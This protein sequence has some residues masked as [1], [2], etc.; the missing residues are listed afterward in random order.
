MKQRLGIAQAMLDSPPVIFMD[1]PVSA[2]DPIGRRDVVEIIRSMGDTT[3]IFSTHI[4]A[5]VENLCD[6][7]LIIEKGKI[8]AQDYLQNLRDR[9]STGA[10]KLRFYNPQEAV[11]FLS[12][13]TDKGL[14]S[15][16]AQA[17]PC[18]ILLG[19]E[20]MQAL[21]RNVI[22]LLQAHGLAIENFGAHTPH[23]EDIFYD[24]ISV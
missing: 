1:E 16:K 14:F 7:I 18:E 5:D 24:V 22:E 19:G 2:L 11:S 15:A 10:A 4:L 20:D 13:A 8:M 12:I 3:V 17:D 9:Y 21:S 23:L 6:Y